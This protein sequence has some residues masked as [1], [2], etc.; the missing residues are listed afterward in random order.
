MRRSLRKIWRW[1]GDR[2]KDLFYATGNQNL[3]LNRVVTGG[4]SL[5]IAFAIY[6]NAIHLGQA[7]DLNGLLTG[8]AAFMAATGLG[9]A[10]KDYARNQAKKIAEKY[11]VED[12]DGNT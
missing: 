10:L 9:I 3:E 2:F 8:L 1:I 6:W 12:S 7:I 5:I 4:M 11:H